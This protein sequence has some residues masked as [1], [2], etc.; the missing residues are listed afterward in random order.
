M[1][2]IWMF[3]GDQGGPNVE[4]FVYCRD[5]PGS[6]TLR[7]E[8]TEA[9]WSFMDGYSDGMIARGPTMTTDRKT[10]TGS[11]HIVD[12]P[13]AEAARVFAFE[14]PNYLAGVYDDV[15]VRRWRNALGRTMWEFEGDPAANRRFLIIGHGT[16]G[17]DATPQALSEERRRSF[18]DRGYAD[19]FIARG[20]L[21][22]D[23][24]T[25]WVGTAML[26]ELRDRREVDAMLGDD[27]YVQAGLYADIE[28]HDW[29]FGGR[30]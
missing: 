18:L 10:A 23:D 15:L 14:E 9:H 16:P 29:E 3:G 22:S 30:R 24:G 21:L 4:Y 13:D 6:G 28:I 5:R 11:M 26:V 27:P 20:P 7:A 19:R 25:A 1:E 8:L 12:L 2:P 17:V